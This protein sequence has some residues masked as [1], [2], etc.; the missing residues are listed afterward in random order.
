VPAIKP[1]IFFVPLVALLSAC[2]RE[3]ALAPSPPSP[4]PATAVAGA[5]AGQSASAPAAPGEQASTTAA[6]PA[7]NT[8]NA[9]AT[10]ASASRAFIDPRT[11][12]LRA[13]TPEELAAL[14]AERAQSGNTSDVKQQAPVEE[15][16]LPG[17]LVEVRLGER[18]RR[19]EKVCV[20]AN[21]QLGPCPSASTKA[22]TG[23]SVPSK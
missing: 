19:E 14:R 1:L 15:I 6:T 3:P 13:P 5:G 20:L 23:K 21:G 12:E 18:A 4:P 7:V 9:A 10:P 17:G 8:G 11:G 16:Q 22:E 2:A